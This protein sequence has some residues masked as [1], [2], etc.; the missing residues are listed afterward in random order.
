MSQVASR[1]KQVNMQRVHNG[2]FCRCNN[3]CLATDQGTIYTEKTSEFCEEI[4]PTTSVVRCS[5]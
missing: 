2:Y 5:L 3:S 4:K 1:A